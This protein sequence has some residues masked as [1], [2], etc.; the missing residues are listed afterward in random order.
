[1][2]GAVN[3]VLRSPAALSGPS[4]SAWRLGVL[5]TR[6]WFAVPAMALLGGLLTIGG[7]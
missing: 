5:M 1:M 6:K 7:L 3:Y 2:D 4:I